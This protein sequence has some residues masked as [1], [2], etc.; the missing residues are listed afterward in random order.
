[1]RY[2]TRPG[3]VLTPI[4]GEYLLISARSLLGMCPYFTQVNETSAFLWEKLI[5]G[6]SREELLQAVMQEYEVDDPSAAG[7]AI[8]SFLNQ[9]LEANYLLEEK[10]GT[11]NEE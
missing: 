9:M 7:A 1:M 10:E 6:A 3:V 5:P 11:E 8:D 2:K 4:C